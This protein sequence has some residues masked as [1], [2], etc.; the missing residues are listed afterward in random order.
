[1]TT[2]PGRGTTPERAPIIRTQSDLEEAWRTLMEPLGFSTGAIWVMTIGPDDRPTPA[3]LEISD[4]ED[5][6]PEPDE[7]AALGHV[8]RMLGEA[9]EPGTRWALLRCRPG[10]GGARAGD[11]A[12]VAALM[13]SC[14][15]A[16]VPMEVAHLATDTVLVALP[17]DDLAR[18]A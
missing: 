3:L 13:A 7:V 2:R 15:A 16:S 9:A 6:P 17:Y 8:L 14:R 18:S 1:M 10:G 11:R 12:L 5:G 4:G